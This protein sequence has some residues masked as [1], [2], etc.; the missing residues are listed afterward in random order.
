MVGGDIKRLGGSG[1]GGGVERRGNK[2][3]T[4]GAGVAM[5]KRPKKNHKK[6]DLKK[7]RKRGNY[8]RASLLLQKFLR[9][10]KYN[11]L[12]QHRPHGVI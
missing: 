6:V 4:K 9:S 7:R 11:G 5:H 1:A 12:S 2:E 3:R 10:F 8:K